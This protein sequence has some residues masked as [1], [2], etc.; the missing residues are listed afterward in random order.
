MKIILG[1]ILIMW[2]GK[3]LFGSTNSG[4]EE[5]YY[6]DL[7]EEFYGK[8]PNHKLTEDEKLELEELDEDE[9]EDDEW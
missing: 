3:L 5:K 8:R 2:L 6:V 1:L 4:Y 9:W 7:H